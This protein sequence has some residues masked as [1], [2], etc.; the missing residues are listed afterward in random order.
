ME[1][2]TQIKC[3]NC[4]T[5]I[6]VQD[7]LSHQLEESIKKKF[8]AELAIEKKKFE[9]QAELLNKA[10]EEFEVRKQNENKL[11]QE[12]FD[13]KMKEATVSME[14]QLKEK[15]EKEQ[16]ERVAKLEAVIKKR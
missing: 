8:Q 14:K 1:N 7:I 15:I 5:D 9:N 13:T 2:I 11:F 12:R 4:G 10:K 16:E 6:D 3:P